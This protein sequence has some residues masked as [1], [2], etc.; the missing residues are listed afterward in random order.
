MSV[1]SFDNPPRVPRSENAAWMIIGD[2]RPTD[3]SLRGLVRLIKG[4]S[5]SKGW[6]TREEGERKEGVVG[7]F[8]KEGKLGRITP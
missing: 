8:W 7:K 1:R 4:S 3:D 2:R 5:C 6:V